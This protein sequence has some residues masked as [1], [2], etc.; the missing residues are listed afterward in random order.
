[1]SARLGL[2]RL[3]GRHMVHRPAPAL[4]LLLCLTLTALLPIAL[5]VLVRHYETD[6]LE[7]ARATPLVLGAPGNRYDLVLQALYFTAET[8]K[9]ITQADVEAVRDTG[10]AHVVPLH[11]GFTARDRPVVGTSLDYFTFRGLT[12]AEGHPPGRLGDC[13]LGADVARALGLGPGD[14]LL[15]DQSDLFNLAADFPLRMRVTG[16]LAWADT[17]DDGAVFTDVRTCW[18][19]AGIGHGHADLATV[20][21]ESDRVLSRDAGSVVGSAAVAKHYE[22]TQANMGAFHFHGDADRFPLTAAIVLP[23]GPRDATLLRAQY[24]VAELQLLDPEQVVRELMDVVLRV[25]RFMDANFAVVC[26]TAG[27]FVLLVLQLAVRTRRR[28]AE[29]LFRIGCARATVWRLQGIE[30][31]CIAAAAGV[32]AAG[33]AVLLRALA[34]ALVRLL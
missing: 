12:V 30:L 32:L 25:R 19:L 10:H 7:R 6:L 23:H 1:M 18:I 21:A 3:A 28:E 8:P 27:L 15:S 22:I 5:H 13:V 34:P 26:T 29:T 9:A 20:S 33:G 11:T 14:T 2:L 24:R 4:L 17:P 16:V 31:A